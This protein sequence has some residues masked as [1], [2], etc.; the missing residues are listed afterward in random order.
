M[1]KYKTFFDGN[2]SLER[3]LTTFFL[4]ALALLTPFVT[5]AETVTFAGAQIE[6]TNAEVS[7]AQDTG[8]L[9]L[10]FKNA[11]SAGSFTLLGS[12]LPGRYLVVG[13]GGAGGTPIS[14]GKNYGQGGGGGAGGSGGC[15]CSLSLNTRPRI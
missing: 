12:A 5:F 11:Q 14:T 13:G 7:Y 4:G 3:M 1:V 8:D 15:F 6:Y 2:R 9:I 10:T